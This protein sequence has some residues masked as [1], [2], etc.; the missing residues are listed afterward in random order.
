MCEQ[1][2]IQQALEGRF[3]KICPSGATI[4]DTPFKCPCCRARLGFALVEDFEYRE[5]SG[6][7]KEGPLNLCPDELEWICPKWDDAEH[8]E[9]EDKRHQKWADSQTEDD[10]EYLRGRYADYVNQWFA[11]KWDLPWQGTPLAK[12]VTSHYPRLMFTHSEG[13]H[14]V[15]HT[16]VFPCLPIF[17]KR[18]AKL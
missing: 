14:R 6:T 1:E 9:R 18:R 11:I 3:G 10:E 16:L 15:A 7:L 4:F 17:R 5:D 13:A 2:Q 12:L 8:G